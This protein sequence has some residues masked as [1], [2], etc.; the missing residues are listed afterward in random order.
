MGRE[1]KEEKE[2]KKKGK[3]EKTDFKR[4]SPIGLDLAQI[5]LDSS[6]KGLSGGTK[7]FKGAGVL[8]KAP[9]GSPLEGEHLGAW[10]KD[11]KP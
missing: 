5:V 8:I 9:C 6:L 7:V 10:W 11:Q 2:R 3:E 4:G 1:R